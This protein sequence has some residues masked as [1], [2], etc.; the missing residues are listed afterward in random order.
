MF[1]IIYAQIQT[2]SLGTVVF[3]TMITYKERKTHFWCYL[4]LGVLRV[5]QRPCDFSAKVY[6]GPFIEKQL[7]FI[8]LA[9][10]GLCSANLAMNIGHGVQGQKNL[11]CEKRGTL[12]SLLLQPLGKFLEIITEKLVLSTQ[13]F[14]D[15]THWRHYY[16]NP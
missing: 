14:T 2:F 1:T 9:F 16:H 11:R 13:H 3:L 6:D 8:K 15:R 5:S 12:A 4:R 10:Y 7:R